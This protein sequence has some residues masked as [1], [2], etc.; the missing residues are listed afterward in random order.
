MSHPIQ[1]IIKVRDTLRDDPRRFVLTFHRVSRDRDIEDNPFNRIS[2]I[3]PSQLNFL[4]RMV[5][6]RARFVDLRSLLSGAGQKKYQVFVHLT[7]DDISLSF[8]KNALPII[9]KYRIP[10]TLFPSIKNVEDG[11][12]WRDQIYYILSRPELLNKFTAKAES[13][14]GRADIMSESSV[15]RWSKNPVFNQKQMEKD[16]VKKVLSE[17]LEN[18]LELVEK[19]K[20]YLSW[21]ELE[22]LAGHDLI[23][24]GN[25]GFAHY[26]YRS[27]TS[28][29]IKKD[30]MQSHVRLKEKLG[31]DPVHFAL[32]FGAI[33]QRSFLA[34]DKILTEMG[35]E[36]AG[37]GK[38]VNN[39]SFR[40]KGLKHYFRIDGGRNVPVNMVKILKA[41]TKTQKEPLR[42]LS[43]TNLNDT[44]ERVFLE[45][46]LSLEDYKTFYRRL[47][48][49]KQHHQNDAYID[50]LYYKNPFR[51][52]NPVHFAIRDREDVFAIGSRFYIPFL[53]RGRTQR[54]AYFCGWFRFPE[55]P[56]KNLRARRIF[57]LAQK[58]IPVFSVYSPSH[59]S[60][61]F[62]KG[63]ARIKVYRLKAPIRKKN[64]GST[65][66]KWTISRKWDP[67]L[68]SIIEKSHS[69]LEISLLRGKEVYEWR[70][71]DY[72]LCTYFYMIP[73]APHP[74][75]YLIF[76]IHE[77]T[78]FISD[79]CLSNLSD[80]I[81]LS[82]M[83]TA[84]FDYGKK[85]GVTDILLETS[86]EL[87]VNLAQKMG[88]RIKET[89]VNVYK[90]SGSS[91]KFLKWD[92]VHE[93]QISGDLLPR[94]ELP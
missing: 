6:K 59:N 10:V 31:I 37:W 49:Q 30:I 14:F 76:C 5:R 88:F 17:E 24:I 29:E 15:Y 66:Q 26:D 22:T 70:I 48:P 86:N 34:V 12:S 71:E 9:E 36:T 8:L 45:E 56:S 58:N 68:Q 78:M 90:Y 73:D 82:K 32:P 81:S 28:V 53:V 75:W 39:P 62:Y 72:P 92:K 7:F 52:E 3:S 35:Y 20:P 25:H 46:S 54:G 16:V 57:E 44:E 38:K 42:G 13:V 74:E 33:G 50:H 65:D 18:F 51:R 91:S 85:Q 93:T 79:F 60:M 83:I 27:L 23:T 55:L 77:K 47:S 41:A 87:L 1:R 64:M 61:H 11:Y 40:G 43:F 2:S 69:N 67:R 80:S 94:F 89:F 4:I 63:W 21:E 19:H 84:A